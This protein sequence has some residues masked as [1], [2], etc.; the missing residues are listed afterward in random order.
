MCVRAYIYGEREVLW[1]GFGM[2]WGLGVV[3]IF[4]LYC[5]LQFNMY[6]VLYNYW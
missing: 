2:G 3:N 6:Y 5:V 1:D 4:I